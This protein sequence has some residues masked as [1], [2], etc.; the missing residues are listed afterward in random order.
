MRIRGPLRFV[1]GDRCATKRSGA[2]CCRCSRLAAEFEA[3]E[4]AFA[5]LLAEEAAAHG[6]DAGGEVSSLVKNQGRRGKRTKW[7][8]T[9]GPSS[10]RAAAAG[11]AWA[12]G[13]TAG[14][15][16]PGAVVEQRSP[17]EDS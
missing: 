17:E 8:D 9:R 15:G 16:R 2:S 5:G 11:T 14:A 10:A 7:P 13:R 6:C 12:E 1:R 4:A 3:F